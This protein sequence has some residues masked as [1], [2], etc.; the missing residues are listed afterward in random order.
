MPSWMRPTFY[1]NIYLSHVRHTLVVNFRLSNEE[2]KWYF[3]FSCSKIDCSKMQVFLTKSPLH[4]AKSVNAHETNIKM[5]IDEKEKKA[6]RK[7][8]MPQNLMVVTRFTAI[9]NCVTVKIHICGYS[10]PFYV[11]DLFLVEFI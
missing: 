7:K 11:S 3:F 5:A 2:P 10:L 9:D 6:R 8:W 1:R 4:I